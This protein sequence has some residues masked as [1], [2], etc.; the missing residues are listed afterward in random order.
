MNLKTTL[1]HRFADSVK[2]VSP[3]RD[4]T[5]SANSIKLRRLQCEPWRPHPTS[6]YRNWFLLWEVVELKSPS[7]GWMSCFPGT[8]YPASMQRN[9]TAPSLLPGITV[10]EELTLT[11]PAKFCC[12]LAGAHRMSL[13]ARHA[14][15]SWARQE[16][17]RPEEGSCENR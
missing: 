6:F 12:S 13:A 2:L 10:T 14:I 9:E 8:C 15:A 17:A 3:V 5:K 7:S 16:V 11:A 1:R 4:L